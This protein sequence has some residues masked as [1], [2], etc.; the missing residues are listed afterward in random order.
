[1]ITMTLYTNC[2]KINKIVLGCL[3]KFISL[4]ENKKFKNYLYLK[5]SLNVVKKMSLLIL[6]EEELTSLVKKIKENNYVMIA[7]ITKLQIT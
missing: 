2:T 5:K 6:Q 4:T 3:E 1:M 7:K